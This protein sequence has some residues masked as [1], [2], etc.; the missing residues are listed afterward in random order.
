MF[1]WKEKYENVGKSLYFWDVIT[2]FVAQK[3]K[4][5]MISALIL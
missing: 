4:H 1:L 2:I 3:Y 5:V